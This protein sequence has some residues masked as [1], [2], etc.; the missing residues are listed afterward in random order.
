[1]FWFIIEFE[2][3]NKTKVQISS[4][5]IIFTPSQELSIFQS[6]WFNFPIQQSSF[7]KVDPLP[8]VSLQPRVLIVIEYHELTVEIHLRT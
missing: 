8:A 4:L 3:Q 7:E 6:L 5:N 1:M 2:V